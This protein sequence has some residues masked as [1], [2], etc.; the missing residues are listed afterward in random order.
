[1][2]Y[3]SPHKSTACYIPNFFFDKPLKNIQFSPEFTSVP[4]IA[5][6]F[7]SSIQIYEIASLI[8]HDPLRGQTT[9]EILQSHSVLCG[10][11]GHF[12]LKESP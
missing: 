9:A 12:Y 5:T 3:I 8:V 7:S 2:Q 4:L 6:Q 11:F 10:K 1:M